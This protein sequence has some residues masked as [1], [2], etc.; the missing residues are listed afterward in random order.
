MAGSTPM[1]MCATV[2]LLI[3]GSAATARAQEYELIM[4]GALDG[5][6]GIMSGGTMT[7]LSGS[8]E[9]TIEAF[10][11]RAGRNLVAP[12]GMPG[13][14]AYTPSSIFLT[15]GGR[16]Y[17]VDA[18]DATHPTG[19]SVAVFDG[20]TPFGPPGHYAVGVIQNPLADGAGIVADYVGASPAFI[21]GSTGV[22]PATFTGYFGVGLQSGVCTQGSGGNCQENAVTPVPLTWSGQSFGL[23]LGNYDED[24]SPTTPTYTAS[25][26]AVP[27]PGA[28][29]LVAAGLPAVI[30]LARRRSRRG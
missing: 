14:V 16:T 21:L 10:F 2:A 12:V 6:S 17:T 26:Q 23:V 3:A 30:M 20:T 5:R 22:V 11:D 24:A 15:M 1:R 27:E 7:P 18:Y 8:T 9:F 28:V 25:I 19:F 13:F 4:Q 29:A